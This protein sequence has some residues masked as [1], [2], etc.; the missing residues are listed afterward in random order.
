MAK[1]VRMEKDFRN[2]VLHFLY[3]CLL[4]RSSI[5]Y[6]CRRSYDILYFFS[7]RDSGKFNEITV[8]GGSIFGTHIENER[9]RANYR[10]RIILSFLKYNNTINNTMWTSTV[11]RGLLTNSVQWFFQKQYRRPNTATKSRVCIQWTIDIVVIGWSMITL[12]HQKRN[13]M[14]TYREREGETNFVFKMLFPIV[15]F[16]N[17]FFFHLGDSHQQE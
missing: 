2:F 10:I 7:T 1:R 13:K 4:S 3:H 17:F 14:H 6:V 15:E 12:L 5:S 9:T 11:F 16:C 8:P